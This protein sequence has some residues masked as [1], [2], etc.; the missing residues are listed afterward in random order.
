MSKT[1]R[2]IL[3]ASAVA[4]TTPVAASDQSRH[5]LFVSGRDAIAAYDLATGA[6]VARF[7]TPGLSADLQ[8]TTAGTLLLN[9]RDSHQ[10]LIVD[11]TRLTEIGRLA[12]RIGGT[13]PVHAYTS[14][15]IG[16]RQ[17]FVALFDGDA[18]AT[19]VG[20][21]A[22]DSSALFI[23]IVPGSPT[24]RQIVGE[25]RL[26]NGH[27]KIAFSPTHARMSVSNIADCDE[28]VGVYDFSDLANIRRIAAF[29]AIAMGL[30]GSTPAR[31]CDVGSPSAAGTV[32][33][34]PHGTATSPISGRHVHNLN[35]TGEMLMIDNVETTPTFTR[36]STRGGSGGAY[37]QI[38]PQ[39]RIAFALQNTPRQGA[40]GT[41]AG[42]DCQIGQ[43][44]I[45]DTVDS[46]VVNEVPVR[47]DGGDCTRS[48][49]GT[50]AAGAR[51]AFAAVS[52]DGRT[53]FVTSGTLP[54]PGARARQLLVFDLADPANPRQLPSIPVGAA[55][56][57][58]D[59][60][61]TGDGRQ[62]IVPANLDGV[63]HIVDMVERA[64]VR[65][66]PVVAQ[67]NRIGT[68]QASG[69]GPSRPT[70]PVARIIN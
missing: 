45:I 36:L 55:D 8:I 66:F 17:F 33:P 35:G 64:V 52:P 21:E 47:Y 69:A 20:A 49:A 67:P 4:L 34:A 32:R 6:E 53:L 28:I 9:H 22:I 46:R 68:Y 56:G 5:T 62:L 12:S 54:Q 25:V 50:D 58:R 10:V 19:Q 2:S 57:H 70:G 29:D 1:L 42:A 30:D 24:Y 59:L 44:A 51:P 16:G 3:L 40:T 39:G 48:L 43:I 63:V 26:G 23:D 65:S 31:T 15:V 61:V 11:A 41:R 13:R 60:A 14:P 18:R 7:A 38:H 37:V 27:H